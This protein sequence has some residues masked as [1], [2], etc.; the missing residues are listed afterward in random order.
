MFFSYS[1]L[2]R[3]IARQ[4]QV[5]YREF[6]LWKIYSTLYI[7]EH[8][9]SLFSIVKHHLWSIS[10]VQVGDT[11]KTS[12]YPRH[13]PGDSEWIHL[14]RRHLSQLIRHALVLLCLHNTCKRWLTAAAR[15]KLLQSI[16]TPT[17]ERIRLSDSSPRL[18]RLSNCWGGRGNQFQSCIH[19][20]KSQFPTSLGWSLPGLM[21]SLR[22]DNP[23]PEPKVTVDP[24]L[25]CSGRKCTNQTWIYS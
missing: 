3:L 16:T 20:S 24:H 21:Q 2:S 9:L 8:S 15:E 18:L 14:G 22:P 17:P 10:H 23:G 4:T 12:S 6:Q 1:S 13:F 5:W 11:N 19:L 7:L 25:P